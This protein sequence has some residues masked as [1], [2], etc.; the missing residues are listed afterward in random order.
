MTQVLKKLEDEADA[1]LIAPIW[2]MQT[3]LPCL[4]HLICEDFQ[5]LPSPQR[6][7]HFPH[8]PDRLTPTDIDEDG[9]FSYIRETLQSQG[10]SRTARDL[11]TKSWRASTK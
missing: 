9:S 3:W 8:T 5:S 11:I 1:I 10:I 4:M 7:L 2:K 6:V